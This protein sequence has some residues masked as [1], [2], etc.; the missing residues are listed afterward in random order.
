MNDDEGNTS[1]RCGLT[2]HRDEKKIE[3]GVGRNMELR[4]YIFA[5]GEAERMEI[6]Y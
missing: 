1:T 5:V 4:K 2:L 6:T 3:W